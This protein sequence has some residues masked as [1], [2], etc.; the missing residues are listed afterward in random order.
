MV[1]HREN[2]DLI[3]LNE[4]VE[5]VRKSLHQIEANT[6]L[7]N[8]PTFW[9]LADLIR[10]KINRVEKLLTECSSKKQAASISSA[11]AS[12]GKSTASDRLSRSLHHLIMRPPN[13]CAGSEFL[14]T[15]D[16]LVE[17]VLL[18]GLGQTRLN[19]LP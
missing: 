13:D 19:A 17:C 7:K 14:R 2:L 11:S 15:T 9:I 18:I 6:C 12:G 1:L 4:K 8:P 16:R 10:C 3:R 5:S